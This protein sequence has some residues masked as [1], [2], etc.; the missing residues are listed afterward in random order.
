MAPEWRRERAPHSW[1]DRSF[2]QEM[3]FICE[4]QTGDGINFANLCRWCSGSTDPPCASRDARLRSSKGMAPSPPRAKLTHISVTGFA[5]F[6]PLKPPPIRAM[7]PRPAMTQLCKWGGR[8][9]RTDQKFLRFIHLRR[10]A[11]FIPSTVPGHD[12]NGSMM[13]SIV[14][15]YTKQTRKSSQC[16]P[17][18]SLSTFLG[19]P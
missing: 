3:Y 13:A 4:F 14:H 1:F 11:K 8:E 5:K 2:T 6:I 9:E 7:P 15:V 12:L 18:G 19:F 16:G 10:F 17:R